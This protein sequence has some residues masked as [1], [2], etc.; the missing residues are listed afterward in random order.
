[1]KYIY[2]LFITSFVFSSCKQEQKAQDP[3]LQDTIKRST[4][5]IKGS[6]TELPMVKDLSKSFS[7]ERND[8]MIDISGGEKVN[9][10]GP[11]KPSTQDYE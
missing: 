2:L 5:V 1:M 6:D 3:E 7:I 10:R 11:P 4:I 9:L 8:I